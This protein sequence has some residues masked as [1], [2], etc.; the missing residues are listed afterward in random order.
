MNNAGVDLSNVQIFNFR[1]VRGSDST[2]SAHA[3]GFAIDV[4]PNGRM[5]TANLP[6]NINQIAQNNGLTW[7]GTW[8]G[9][10]Y[11]P[12]HF[13]VGPGAGSVPSDS[14]PSPS[15]GGFTDA[16]LQSYYGGTPADA[17]AGYATDSAQGS[18]PTAADLGGPDAGSGSA[19]PI[20]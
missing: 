20:Y 6:D 7:S 10:S 16:Q 14:G 9:A 19:C 17:R 11:D 1:N 8:H 2:L 15:L 13:E 12:A 18:A 3:F 5:T 4:D